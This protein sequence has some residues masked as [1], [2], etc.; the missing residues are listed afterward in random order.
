M[1]QLGRKYAATLGFM[2]EGGFDDYAMGKCIITL[3]DEGQL[4][5]YLMF[6]QTRRYGRIAIVHL[7]IDDRFRHQGLHTKLLDALRERYENSGVQGM[8]LNCRRDYKAASAMW[9]NYGFIP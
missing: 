2:P 3:S 4:K 7:V 1:K 5:G 8:V 9:A 6:R